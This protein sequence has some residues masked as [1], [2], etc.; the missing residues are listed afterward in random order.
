MKAGKHLPPIVHLQLPQEYIW[1]LCKVL[2]LGLD[3]LNENDEGSMAES[4]ALMQIIMAQLKGN[5]EIKINGDIE[6]G[7]SLSDEQADELAL[8]ADYHQT[9]NA[10][11]LVSESLARRDLKLPLLDTYAELKETDE[12][13]VIQRARDY[14]AEIS[15]NSFA[16]FY[17]V[18]DG[19][20][21]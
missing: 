19:K 1:P 14:I 9:N 10:V 7:F 13:K 8:I 5:T 21:V 18:K 11:S 3:S 6:S 2:F 12:V 16:N 20:I 15:K 17:V 4:A